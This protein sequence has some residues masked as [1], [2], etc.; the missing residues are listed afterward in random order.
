MLLVAIKRSF[1]SDEKEWFDKKW[2]VEIIISKT[3]GWSEI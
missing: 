1:R 2:L 3:N